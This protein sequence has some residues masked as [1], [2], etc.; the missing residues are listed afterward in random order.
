MDLLPFIQ[1]YLKKRTFY[2]SLY[3]LL[4]LLGFAAIA[5]L[6]L[7][8]C[9]KNSL[10]AGEALDHLSY[11][12]ALSF[13]LIPVHEYIHVLAYRWQGAA[14]TS[15]DVNWKKFYFM[16][17]ADQFVANRK[18]FTIV[19]LAPFALITAC[20]LVALLLASPIWQFMVAG[21][22]FTHTACCSG[23]FGL[24]SYFA[25]QRFEEMATYDDQPNKTTYFFGKKAS[26][27]HS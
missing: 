24:L 23:D 7:V 9:K 17:I 20:L 19:A 4:N 6:F 16:A 21:M 15:Y 22:Y 26:P 12:I 1:Q 25:S 8:H 13:A 5:V 27:M 14:H 18:E 3:I 10:P 2:S 11:G